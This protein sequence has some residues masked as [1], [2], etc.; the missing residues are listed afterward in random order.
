MRLGLW[1]KRGFPRGLS[2]FSAGLGQFEDVPEYP[3]F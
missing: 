3:F 2:G 1:I